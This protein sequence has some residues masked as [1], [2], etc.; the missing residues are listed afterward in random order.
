[1]EILKKYPSP[2]WFIKHNSPLLAGAFFNETT[3]VATALR[4]KDISDNLYLENIFIVT[5]FGERM[6]IQNKNID[7]PSTTGVT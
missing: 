4:T 3:R 5:F 1:M 6:Y 2:Q 7:R